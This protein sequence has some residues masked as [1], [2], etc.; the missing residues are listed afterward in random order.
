MPVEL[1][2]KTA[3]QVV[4]IARLHGSGPGV[5][6]SLY[7]HFANWPE[8]LTAACSRIEPLLKDGSI[9]RARQ[10]AVDF[11]TA[12]AERLFIVLRSGDSAVEIPER[13]V[14][15][16]ERFINRV[17]PEMLPVGLALANALPP[18]E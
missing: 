18:Q 7:L 5:V 9:E 10:T 2:P 6:P 17:I 8:F 4:K 15:T 1:N 11:A 14:G 16:L 3:D 13:V 12:E